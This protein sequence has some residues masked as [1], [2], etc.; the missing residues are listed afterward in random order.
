MRITAVAPYV[1]HR[2]IPHAGGQYLYRY[3]GELAKV[4]DTGLIAPDIPANRSAVAGAPDGVEVHLFAVPPLSRGWPARLLR[5]VR[6]AADGLSLALGEGDAFAQ[7]AKAEAMVARSDV[8][9]THWS[10]TLPLIPRIQAWAPRVKVVAFEQDVRYQSLSRRASTGDHLRDRFLATVAA[11]RVRRREPAYLN[12]CATVLTFT[13]KDADLLRRLGVGTPIDLLTPS[14]VHP[15]PPW[16]P[17][18]EPMVLFVGAFDRPENSESA[19]WF[20]KNSWPAVTAACP[21]ATVVLAGANPPP[22]LVRWASDHVRVTGFVEDLDPV[23]VRR[24]EPAHRP[25]RRDQPAAG[26]RRPRAGT[27]DGRSGRGGGADWC[28]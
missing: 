3:L 11:R 12:R 10:E 19:T 15:P 16:R 22:T 17:A 7:D 4:A 27:T 9:E 14:L 18:A 24:S 28:R 2:Q 23:A 20:L 26:R 1:P 5:Y 8:V 13:Q 21:E 25:Q 6:A